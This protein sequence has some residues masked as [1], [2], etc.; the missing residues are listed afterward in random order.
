MSICDWRR[1]SEDIAAIAQGLHE[2]KR[3][4][5]PFINVQLSQSMADQLQCARIW[6][7]HEAPVSPTPLWRGERYSH[8]KIRIAYVSAD[9]HAHATSALMA[10]VFEQHDRSRFET[11]AIS[12]GPDDRS[13]M[14]ARVMGAFDRFI[15]V[16]T[17][18]DGEI[19]QTLRQMEIDIAV[20]LKGYTKQNR[21]RIFAHRAAPIQVNYLG[22]PGTMGAPYI[23][24]IIADRIV[25]PDEHR[26]Y[27]DERVVYLP[28]TYQCNDSKR[29]L[30]SAALSRKAAG[31]PDHA[32][33][34]CCFNN[35]YKI[36]PAIFSVWMRLL[37]G[38]EG[39]V[40]WLLEDT[41]E[42]LANLRREAEAAGVSGTR[43]VAAQRTSG[44]E[45]LAR[46]CLAD[47]FLDTQPYGAHTTASDA[48]WM[49]LP[50]LTVLGP[51]FASRVAASLLHAAGAPE[52]I[53]PSLHD[54][55]QAALR[56]AREPQALAALK[57]KLV[58]NRGESTLFDTTRFTRNLES[59]Y[60]AMWQR[61]QQ[62]AAPA[63]IRL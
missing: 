42:A 21:S 30:M 51:T 46:H 36:V 20:D 15:D 35:N 18:S 27:F 44:E 57:A 50:V 17:K 54:Y 40:L 4:V 26:A 45:H 39:S 2:G 10:G 28:D 41:P 62:G 3:I 59:A 52:L 9:F 25:V 63:D 13:A 23:D 58:H 7:A 47:L 11:V 8:G 32:F 24:Y 16:Q 12:F 31:L 33:V 14:R 19:A 22:Y 34:Y 53:A 5:N 48:L 49:G 61:H 60:A 29:P 37:R 1:F 6:T 38:V 56:F 55:E 43:I